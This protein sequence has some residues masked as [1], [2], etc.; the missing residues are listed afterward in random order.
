LRYFRASSSRLKAQSI[1]PSA[2]SANP[3]RSIGSIFG[4]P[5]LTRTSSSGV[6]ATSGQPSTT[7][8]GNGSFS[9]CLRAIR[10]SSVLTRDDPL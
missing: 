5:V 6:A 3:S 1:A 9:L 2:G 10:P 7:T 4:L 8:M